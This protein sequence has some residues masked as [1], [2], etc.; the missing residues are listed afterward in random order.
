MF[1]IKKRICCWIDFVHALYKAVYSFK[2]AI[3]NLS[4]YFFSALY[5]FVLQFSDTYHWKSLNFT[6]TFK[7]WILLRSRIVSANYT[8]LQNKVQ[9]TASCWHRSKDASMSILYVAIKS[10]ELSWPLHQKL[11]IVVAYFCNAYIRGNNENRYPNK[12][13]ILKIY[14]SHVQ[15]G[16][17]YISHVQGVTELIMLYDTQKIY[18]TTAVLI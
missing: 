8:A 9:Y 4:L 11:A 3:W 17:T 10:D 12:R 5:S 16:V 2:V 7:N 1:D 6:F 14:L 13:L 15:A 18:H